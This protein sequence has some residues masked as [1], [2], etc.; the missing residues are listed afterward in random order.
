MDINFE[1]LDALPRLYAV[2]W[3]DDAEVVLLYAEDLADLHILIDAI[4]D[5]SDA[6]FTVVKHPLGL[7]MRIPEVPPDSD[8]VEPV[9]LTGLDMNVGPLST[10]ELVDEARWIKLLDVP[11]EFSPAGRMAAYEE[12]VG[13]APGEKPEPGA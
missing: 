7:R 10:Y 13:H 3:P 5:P 1:D 9:E 11:H 2:R 4:D 12:L 8:D 6:E